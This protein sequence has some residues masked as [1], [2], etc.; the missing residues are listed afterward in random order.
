MVRARLAAR[1][2]D[3][4]ELRVDLIGVNALHGAASAPG[5]EPYEV[6]LRVAARTQN[7]RHADYVAQEVQTLLT[8]GPYGGGGDFTHVREVVGV[9]SVLL[10]RG[11]VE[12]RVT[13][14]A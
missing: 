6:R 10:P 14:L 5:H 3:L 8:N 9:A 1:A 12:P 11:L 4:D 7:R 13:V 2:L